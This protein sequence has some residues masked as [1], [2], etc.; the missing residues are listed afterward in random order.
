MEIYWG[1]DKMMKDSLA[2]EKTMN[3]LTPKKNNKK[4]FKLRLLIKYQN[5]LNLKP[6][7]IQTTLKTL[8]NLNKTINNLRNP[9]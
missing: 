2:L 9:V 4:K 5:N 6:K 8:L 7:S 3:S 1:V